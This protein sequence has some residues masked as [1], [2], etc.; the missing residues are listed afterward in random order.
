MITDLYPMLSWHT[1]LKQWRVSHVDLTSSWRW[2]YVDI[3]VLH[4]TLVI[5]DY[6]YVIPI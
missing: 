1:S 2:I 4:V 5:G 3:E 6:L